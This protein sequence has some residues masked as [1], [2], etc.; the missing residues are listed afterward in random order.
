L[1]TFFKNK[2]TSGKEKNAKNVN[3]VTKIKKKPKKGFYLY[4][5]RQT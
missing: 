2:K 4:D 3:N 5:F 1:P